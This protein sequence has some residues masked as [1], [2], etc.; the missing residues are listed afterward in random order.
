M[1]R[2]NQDELHETLIKSRNKRRDDRDPPPPPPPLKDSDK[3]KRTKHDSDTSASRQP[4]GLLSSTWKTSD[5]RDTPAQ[6]SSS[7]S[8]QKQASQSHLSAD[9]IPTS[10]EVNILDSEDA[11][12][13]HLPKI[14]T[15]DT[16]LRPLL[17]EDRPKTLEPN[18]S[19]S[20]NDLPETEND[21]ENAL[22]KSYKDPEENKLLQKTGD[23]GSFIKWLCKR[24]GKKK[25]SKSDLE[26][27]T[28]N[29]HRLL[30]DQVDLVNPEGHRIV[31]DV[32]KPLPLGGPPGQV[33]I[34]P[35]FFFNKDLDYLVSGDKDQRNALSISKLKSARYLDFGLKELVSSLNIVIRQLVG[36][37]QLGIKS[38][39]T[40]LNLTQPNWDASDFL[41]KEDY[42]IISKPRAVIYRDRNDM[43]KMMRIQEVYKFSDGTLSRV[44]DKLDHI[45]KDFKLFEYN[46]GMENSIWS[47]D[48]KRRSEEFIEVIERRLKI[49]RIFKSLETFVCGRLRDVDYRLINR[50]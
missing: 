21:W 3:S 11:D 20:P 35:H 5:T 6:T 4:P 39:Q 17:E 25:L 9:D 45:V 30:T 1:D 27:P 36:D 41:F 42:T 7:S 13:A 16:W 12:A 37:L 32:S 24:I 28:F 46:W 29:C 44:L 18:W 33:T 8:K 23:M 50:T 19:V 48:D 47:E 40:K 15:P 38:Y 31:P 10:D 49:K 14:R 26:G 2:A 34:Q 43:N 22:T